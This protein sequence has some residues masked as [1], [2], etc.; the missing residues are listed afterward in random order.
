MYNPSALVELDVFSGQNNPTW[1]LSEA[2]YA[3]VHKRIN[4]LPESASKSLQPLPVL[5]YRGLIIKQECQHGESVSI[6]IY[7]GFVQSK[8]LNL[9]DPDRKLEKWLLGTGKDVL[10]PTMQIYL[11]NEI[12]Q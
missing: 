6:R 10:G 2:E 1:N 3:E 7:R 9:L 5:G 12:S 11:H 8:Q 4:L